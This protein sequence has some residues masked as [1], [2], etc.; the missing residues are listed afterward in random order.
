MDI[1]VYS[2]GAIEALPP[3][4]VPHLLISITSAPEDQARLRTSE[5]TLGVLRLSF[6]D[7][8][9]PTPEFPEASLFGVAEARRIWEFVLAHRDQTQRIVIHCDAGQ[10]RS[11]AVAAALAKVFDGDDSEFFRRYRPNRRVFRTLLETYF[12]EYDPAR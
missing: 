2:R 9:T 6:P 12:T 4:E 8:D 5:N 10:C 7:V 3:H 1:R 11:P